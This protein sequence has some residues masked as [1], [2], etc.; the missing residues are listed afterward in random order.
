MMQFIT[1]FRRSFDAVASTLRSV[2]QEFPNL[3]SFRTKWEFW[4][5][6]IQT[7][8]HAWPNIEAVFGNQI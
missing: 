3:S 2:R 4:C 5:P 8:G 6:T 7:P 1:M